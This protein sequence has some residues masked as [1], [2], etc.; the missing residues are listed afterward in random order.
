MSKL[1]S[2]INDRE[3]KKFD[4]DLAGD[5]AVRTISGKTFA[6]MYGIVVAD[7]SRFDRQF[8]S[9]FVE[10]NPLNNFEVIHFF[11]EGEE[12]FNYVLGMNSVGNIGFVRA[13]TNKDIKRVLFAQGSASAYDDIEK[14]IG[15]FF[16]VGGR[17]VVFTIIQDH[18]D[19]FE[20][21]DGNTLYTNTPIPEGDY[22][23]T[24]KVTGD[25]GR[26]YV[27][28]FT[29]NIGPTALISNINLSNLTIEDSSSAGD[30][31]GVFSTVGGEK[32]ITYT[33]ESQTKGGVDVDIFEIDDDKL[34]TK[35]NV[36]N[37]GD[38]YDI[39]ITAEDARVGLPDGARTRTQEFIIDVVEDTF[40]NSDSLIF[41]GIDELLF[42]EH[43][44]SFDV[45]Q[46]MTFSAWINTDA[47]DAARYIATK[48]REAGHRAWGMRVNNGGTLSVIFSETGVATDTTT[49]VSTVIVGQWTH[50]AFVFDGT[51]AQP[52]MRIYIDSVLD[53]NED[54]ALT[55]IKNNIDVDF[56]IGALGAADPT[57]AT[58]YFDGKIDEVAIYNEALTI[59][60]IEEIYNNGSPK[61][62]NQLTSAA[63]GVS[64]W[65]MGD[66][67]ASGTQPDSFGDNDL[68]DENMNSGNISTDVPS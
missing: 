54:T 49:S 40:I 29:I 15:V 53:I 16:A 22:R 20:I 45:G 4:L 58:N 7:A 26:E 60:Q 13:T 1:S 33:I 37:I 10:V 2:S 66:D 8:D 3:F 30:I 56:I 44:N 52:K 34:I 48:F 27:D 31:V 11:Q 46:K 57:R 12:K 55:A 62:L 64:W 24:I 35:D 39:Y 43:N 21:R 9:S 63:D 68:S 18:S 14:G 47:T 5:T 42:I 17:G 50:V 41:N 38:Q 61:N 67:F 28:S 23:I 51:L 25:G 6:D 65:R 36:G 59:A 32:P 19:Y